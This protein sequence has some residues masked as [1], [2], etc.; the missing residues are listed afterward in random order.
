MDDKLNRSIIEPGPGPY[1]ST[2]LLLPKPKGGIRFVLD[3]RALN[4]CVMSDAYTLP[5]VDKV[6]SALSR[7]KIFS[8]L[9]IKEAF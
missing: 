7:S 5:Q 9:D 4:D 6:L 2:V 8:S 1:S 3:Y